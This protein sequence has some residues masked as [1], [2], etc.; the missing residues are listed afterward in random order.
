MVK[1]LISFITIVTLVSCTTVT[2]V[3][4]IRVSG[5]LHH[6]TYKPLRTINVNPTSNTSDNDLY[7]PVYKQSGE[8]LE[9]RQIWIDNLNL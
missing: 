6:L 4:N 7:Q 1:L 5:D 2:P 8:N 3:K 9:T